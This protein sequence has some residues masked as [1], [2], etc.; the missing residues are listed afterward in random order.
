MY[1]ALNKRPYLTINYLQY[2]KIKPTNYSKKR[3]IT[4]ASQN[5]E[6]IIPLS[7]SPI[8]MEEYR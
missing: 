4:I 3:N 6:E 1:K 5:V 8:H 7:R 2:E